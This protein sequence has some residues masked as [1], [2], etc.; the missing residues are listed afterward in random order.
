[1]PEPTRPIG[2]ATRGKTARNRL[3]RVDIFLI[4][5]DPNLLRRIDGK[6]QSAY[7]VDLGFGQEP[8]TTV[9]SAQHFR[10][11]NPKLAVLGVEIDPERVAA[12][13]PYEGENLAFR[14]GGFN[15]PLKEHETTRLVRAFNVL[16]QYPESEVIRAYQSMLTTL[17]PEGLIIEGTSDPYGRIWA[18]NLIRKNSES[19]AEYEGLAFSTNFRWG[20]DPGL[21]QSV[22]PKN[23]IHHMTEGEVIQQFFS[24]W[25]DACNET[26]GYKQY[27]LRHWFQES[28]S[29]LGQK[30]Y[31]IDTRKKFLRSGYLVW[32]V[33]NLS[34][35]LPKK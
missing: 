11:L 1:M 10:K 32:K 35:N 27:G 31:S 28:A 17:L 12:A 24:D 30:G 14:L 26:I 25:K 23:L 34:M 5:Y 3:R 7:Y 15:I 2:Q 21:F 9:E 20:F 6:F 33:P 22:L 8:I 13:K 16:R 19:E 18:A 4:R 29:A